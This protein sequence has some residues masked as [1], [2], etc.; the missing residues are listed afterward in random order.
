MKANVSKILEVCKPLIDEEG[1]TISFELNEGLPDISIWKNARGGGLYELQ[2]DV[3]CHL[4]LV[5]SDWEE[6]VAWLEKAALEQ[7][8]WFKEADELE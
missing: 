5:T 6:V 4:E 7:E 1:L 3:P 8:A 2:F